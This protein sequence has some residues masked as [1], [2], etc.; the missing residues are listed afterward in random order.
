MVIVIDAKGQTSA[1]GC[2]RRLHHRAYK[3]IIAA[4]RGRRRLAV[5]V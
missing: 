2:R 4:G 1:A 5:G 3:Q